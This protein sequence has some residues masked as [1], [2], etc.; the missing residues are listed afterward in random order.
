V[1]RLDAD[2]GTRGRN[3]DDL[4]TLI[5]EL[6]PDIE[7]G[8]GWFDATLVALGV[9]LLAWSFPGPA[10]AAVAGALC[11]GLGLILPIRSLWRQMRTRV[12]RRRQRAVLDQGVTL[13]VAAPAPARLVDAYQ[14]LCQTAEGR[15]TGFAAIA[16]GHAA[17][18][19][20]ATLL[21]GRDP[22]PPEAAYVAARADAVERLADAFAASGTTDAESAGTAP[23]PSALLEARLELDQLSP[24][25]SLSRIDQLADE[26]RRG[27][28]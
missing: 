6:F 13:A 24:F 20:S 28:A 22:S 15:A 14:R 18:L 16:A 25:S 2:A 17:V 1:I 5:D 19:E 10:G 23:G 7:G 8:P 21:Q 26:A 9:G 3:P 4:D 27:D 11:L 12:E